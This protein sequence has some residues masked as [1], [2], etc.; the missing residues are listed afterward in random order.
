MRPSWG[1]GAPPNDLHFSGAAQ[2]SGT[3]IANLNAL[4]YTL[5]NLRLYQR[6]R[7]QCSS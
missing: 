1:A 4:I 6:L 3:A 7:Q 5:I 2:R